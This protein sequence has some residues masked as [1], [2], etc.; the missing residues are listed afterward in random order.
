MPLIEIVEG[1]QT[2]PETMQAAITFAQAIRKQPI[3]CAEVPGFVVNRVLTAGISEVF[4]AQEE[5]GLSIKAIDAG[6]AEA[7]VVADGA[8]LPDQR[9][10]PRHRP[11]RRRAPRRRPTATTASTSRRTCSGSSP[12]ASSGPRPAATAFYDA[13]GKPNVDGDAEPDVAELVE[14]LS[15]KTFV[16]A[17]LVLEE[18]VASHRDIDFGMIGGAGMDP[19]RGLLPPF[20]RA[21]SRGPRQRSRGARAR[22]ASATASASRRRR[23]CAGSSPRG[24]SGAAE[25]PGLLRLRPAR[26]RPAGGGGGQARDTRRRGDRLDGQ[27]PSTA[28]GAAV[29]R[30]F[31]AIWQTRI[32]GSDVRALVIASANPML[33]CAGADISGFTEVDPDSDASVTDAAHALFRGIERSGLV[34]IAAVNGIAF[35]GGC[36]LAMACDVRLA[37]RSALFGQPEIKL[38][39]IPGFGGTQRLPRLVGR[40]T[41]ARDE[42]DRRPDHGRR[43][44]RGRARQSRHR[45]P[46]ADRHGADVGAA[47]RRPGAAGRRRDQ[48]LQRARPISTRASRRRRRRSPRCSPATTRGRGSRRSW[49]S[50]R[51]ASKVAKSRV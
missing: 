46:R 10:R 23:S 29:L 9:A 21:D 34:T 28:M 24:G 49:A 19:R 14:L 20:M 11:A 12:R 38:G 4:R 27:P 42:P 36:E 32:E 45:G 15:L 30:D 43:G 18:G 39:I 51:R 7:G 44:V 47:A 48:A 6:F 40:G 37:A 26:R 41:G 35:G 25:R 50:A 22:R 1:D 5:Q 3:T 16:E 33:F 8:V 17:C 2:S 31:A 13:Q